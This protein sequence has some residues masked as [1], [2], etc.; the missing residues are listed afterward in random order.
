MGLPGIRYVV[1][2]RWN[3]EKGLERRARVLEDSLAIIVVLSTL[4]LEQGPA[5]AH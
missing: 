1:D 3:E 4:R 5:L 2:E